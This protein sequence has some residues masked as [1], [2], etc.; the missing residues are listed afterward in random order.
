LR[1]KNYFPLV[2]S[3]ASLYW[4][5]IHTMPNKRTKEQKKFKP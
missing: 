4:S 3:F 2:F 5:Y 1:M